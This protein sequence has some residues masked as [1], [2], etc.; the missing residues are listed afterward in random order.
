[1]ST[2]QALDRELT[3]VLEV[4]VLATD[5]AGW[6]DFSTVSV[7]VTDVNDNAPEFH[8]PEYHTC[9]SPNL[10]ADSVFLKVINGHIHLRTCCILF[11][12]RFCWILKVRNEKY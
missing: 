5:G 9:I 4:S 3:A 6:V 7:A 8:F 12:L 2:G 1:M 11:L 10:T